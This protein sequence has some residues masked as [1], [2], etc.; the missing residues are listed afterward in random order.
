M[1]KSQ[2]NGHDDG[3]NTDAN[4]ESEPSQNA[5]V[6]E[7]DFGILFDVDGVLARGSNPL[8]P[9]VQAMGLLSDDS[10]HLRVP[11][12]FV[13]NATNRSQDKAGQI[14]KWFG[15]Q[16]T[17]DM[18]IHAPT[19]ARLL[20]KYHDKHVLI[21]GQEHRIEIAE[22][23]GFS[24][25]C[26]I[27][28]IQRAYPLLDMVDHENR[29]RVA[30]DPGQDDHGF[31]T[32]EAILMIGEPAQWE[33]CLQLLVDLL[34]TEG[35]PTKSPKSRSAIKQLP[36]IA[37]NMDLVYMAE[38]CMP[39][40]GHGAFLV[41]LEA[42]FKKL[43]G[44]DLEY[45]A[46]VGKPCEITYRYAEH[47]ISQVAKQLGFTRPLT[48]L[49]FIGDNPN[50]DIAG[51]NLYDRYLKKVWYHKEN[52]NESSLHPM[53]E[54]P[55]SRTIPD[56]SHLSEQ[57]V[58]EVNSVLVGT[59][60]YDPTHKRKSDDDIYHGHRDIANE[61]DLYKPTKFVD[62]VYHAIKHILEQEKFLRS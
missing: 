40:F 52:A 25:I 17:P 37:C 43:T 49:Y 50:V 58:R 18:V 19:P 14:Q 36:I 21:I 45:T 51:A 10:G 11:V 4:E 53:S 41:C 26:T 62:D 29:Q 7:P 22:D 47:T 15:I 31:P 6:D 60:V 61:P 13:T 1:S 56:C 32:V 9:A 20:T 16:V 2:K 42:L 24:N 55:S 23:L 5:P 3:Y 54:L 59:G 48:K 28:D 35:K 12:A 33:S 44:K 8:D 57:N 27:E 34:L 38:A 39:R 30:K 46:L